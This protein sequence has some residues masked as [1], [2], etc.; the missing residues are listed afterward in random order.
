VEQAIEIMKQIE[1]FRGLNDTQVARLAGITQQETLEA[2]AVVF[3]Q[4]APADKMYFVHSGQVEIRINDQNRQGHAAIY[5]GTGQVFGEMALVDQG[6]RS[7]SVLAV[8]ECTVV[9]SIP[10]DKFTALC[11]EDTA[12]GYILMRN[13]AQDLS[14]KMRHRQLDPSEE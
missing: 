11:D 9:Y 8:E 5:L 13:I 3:L 7:A 1:L 4:D 12:I 2:G 14:F 6:A 10:N